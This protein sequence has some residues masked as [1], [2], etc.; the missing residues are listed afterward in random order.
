MPSYDYECKTCGHKFEVFQ[1]MNDAPL[2]E[3]PRCSREVR[4]LIGGGLGIIFKGSGFYVTDNKK[5]S[6]GYGISSGKDD[7]GS[8]NANKSETPE[9]TKAS[10][11]S[12]SGGD[13]GSGGKREAINA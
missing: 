13:N 4:R 9:S 5:S 11:A 7:N 8:K 3:C 6:V 1:S 12:V 10:D 2:K